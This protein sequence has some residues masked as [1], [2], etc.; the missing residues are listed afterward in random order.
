M[1]LLEGKAWHLIG[2]ANLVEHAKLSRVLEF[3]MGAEGVTK[4]LVVL[5]VAEVE[6]EVVLVDVA[7]V[8]FVGVEL[9]LIVNEVLF[10]EFLQMLFKYLHW[11]H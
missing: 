6:L 1:L 9:E 4:V 3:R 2:L 8:Y 7:V 5:D 11:C 10:A